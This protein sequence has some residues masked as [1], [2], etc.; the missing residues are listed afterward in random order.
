MLAKIKSFG[1]QGIKGY[2]V[3]I[4]IDINNGLP[5]IEMVGLPDASIKESK[6]RIRSAIKNSKF[7]FSPSKVTINLAPADTKKEGATYDL[8]IAI[9][10]LAATGQIDLGEF[11]DTIMMGELSLDGQ[12]R[13]IKGI[14]PALIEARAKGTQTFFIPK[15]NESEASFVEGITVYSFSSLLEVTEF[16]Q[17]GIKDPIQKHDIRDHIKGIK[18]DFDFKYVKGQFAAKRALEIAASGGHNVLMIGPPGAGKTLLARC[19]PTILPDMTIDEVLETTKIH[20]VVGVL[21][22]G[23]GVV[24]HRPY[25]SPHHTATMIALAGGGNAARPGEIS[26]AHNGVLF[27]DELLEYPRQTLEILRQPLEDN[28]ITISRAAR[29]VEYPASFMLV[30]SMNP[31]PCGYYGSE[32]VECKCT[33]AQIV[34]YMAKLSGP[35]LDRIDIHLE[36]DNVTYDDLAS[37]TDAEPSIDIRKRVNKAREIQLARYSNA[38]NDG[39]GVYCNAKISNQSVKEHCTLDSTGESIIRHAFDQLK[40]SA[41]SYIR[42][43]KVARTIADLDES[44]NIMP[45]HIAEAIQYRSLDRKYWQ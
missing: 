13:P 39:R 1:L 20:S 24:I 32:I 38:I 19:I 11:V 12:L 31:C 2:D 37:K 40:L 9:G 41:R 28:K 45:I 23:S 34:K 17:S 43:L 30:A 44:K 8:P 42:I 7:K 14:L 33:P 16:L 35:L 15:D 4:E 25:R 3:C 21:P 18:Q 10:V 26:L 29:N 36:I 27:L 6:E 5:S 22:E